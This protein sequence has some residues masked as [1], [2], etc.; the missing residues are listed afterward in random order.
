MLAGHGV[1]IDE[2][3]AFYLEVFLISGPLGAKQAWALLCP[4]SS[5]FRF[6]RRPFS[7]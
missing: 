5:H 3:L 2:R 1:Y 6:Y 4:V 7:V